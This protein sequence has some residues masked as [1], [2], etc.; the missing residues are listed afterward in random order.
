MDDPLLHDWPSLSSVCAYFGAL[1]CLKVL[2]ERGDHFKVGDRQCRS[3]CHFAVRGDLKVVNF[4][5]GLGFDF[6]RQSSSQ[7]DAAELRSFGISWMC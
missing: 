2:A 6:A 3:R 7:R 5:S 4:L 1:N